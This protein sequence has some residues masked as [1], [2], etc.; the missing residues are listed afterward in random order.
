[1]P[2][3]RAEAFREPDG[4]YSWVYF[5]DGQFQIVGGQN[6]TLSAAVNAMRDKIALE[7]NVANAQTVTLAADIP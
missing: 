3:F 4:Q 2:N 7:P 1:M 5:K 6:Q